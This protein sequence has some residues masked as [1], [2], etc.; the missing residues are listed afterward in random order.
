MIAVSFTHLHS[1]WAHVA[2]CTRPQAKKPKSFGRRSS[3]MALK[4][5]LAVTEVNL[6]LSELCVDV[7]DDD[8]EHEAMGVER[9]GLSFTEVRR[10]S[11]HR[12][13]SRG[14]ISQPELQHHH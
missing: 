9:S 2:W 14:R 5:A 1:H 6:R 11:A 12:P 8:E 3:I 4:A 7:G 10:R 13:V